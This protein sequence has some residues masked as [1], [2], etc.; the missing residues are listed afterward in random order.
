MPTQTLSPEILAAALQG[1]ES[2]RA[3]IDTQIAD[4]QRLLRNG[5]GSAIAKPASLVTTAA[6]E[7]PRARRTMSASARRRIADAQKKRWAAFHQAEAAEKKPVAK[8]TAVKP[9]APEA[10][11]RK[12][13]MSAA[14]RKRIIEA[15]KKRW[16]AFHKAQKSSVAAKAAA[17]DGGGE[18]GFGREETVPGRIT[19]KLHQLRKRGS[20]SACRVVPSRRV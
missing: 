10:P 15:T 13:K 20:D 11:V 7:A 8:A 9:T 4:V 19:P 12:R 17:E 5:S 16:A 14:G 18:E 6:D 1:L 3:L 2:Q